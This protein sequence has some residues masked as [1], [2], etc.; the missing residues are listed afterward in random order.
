MILYH[1]IPCMLISFYNHYNI[2]TKNPGVIICNNCS[3]T[4]SFD[5]SH[6]LNLIKAKLNMLGVGNLLNFSSA[7]SK[8]KI[9]FHISLLH[10]LIIQCGAPLI[11]CQPQRIEIIYKGKSWY[12]STSFQF[13]SIPRAKTKDKHIFSFFRFP[14][15]AIINGQYYSLVF[16]R[17]ITKSI[18]I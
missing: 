1:F 17:I 15:L 8:Y 7:I 11:N 3:L 12:T 6:F 2:R 16:R 14:Y 10:L 4:F 9:L 18:N 5:M 13:F